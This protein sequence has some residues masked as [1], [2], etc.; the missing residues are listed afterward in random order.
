VFVR[1]LAGNVIEH[2][3]MFLLRAGSRLLLATFNPVDDP[4]IQEHIRD[5]SNGARALVVEAAS[6]MDENFRRL[7]ALNYDVVR[8]PSPMPV[9]KA[10]DVYYPTILNGI[11][12]VT[13]KNEVNVV[14]PTYQGYQDDVQKAGMSVIQGAFEGAHIAQVEAMEAARRQGAVHCLTLV[15]PYEQSWFYDQE[16]AGTYARIIKGVIDVK[17]KEIAKI[18]EGVW[19]GVT[20]PIRFQIT[21][22]TIKMIVAGRTEHSWKIDQIDVTQ[23]D[24]SVQISVHDDD[25]KRRTLSVNCK[26]INKITVKVS[27]PNADQEK[28]ER[29]RVFLLKR[30]EE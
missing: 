7:R 20:E 5:L 3:D 10:D 1:T 11:V 6:A 24:E 2:I 30:I 16:R 25:D 17:T 14:L 22:A 19:K 28:G 13:P 15:V 21:E 4:Q 12:W 23:G 29:D 9:V 26:E 27:D 8:V 18:L